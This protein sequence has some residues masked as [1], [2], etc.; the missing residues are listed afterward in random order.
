M[1][2]LLLSEGH[3]WRLG[4]GL[5]L[6]LLSHLSYEAFYFQ[7]VTIILSAAALSGRK[8][9]D[10]PWRL[11][12]SAIFLNIGCIAFN[13]LGVGGIQKSFNPDF[14]QSF[15]GGYSHI[16][17]I[18]GHAVREHRFLV[19]DAVIGAALCGS[20]YLSRLVGLARFQLSLL[21]TIG[22]IVA[23]G[24][25]YAMAGY[26]LAAEGPMARVS[27]VIATYFSIAGGVLAASSSPA[28][29]RHQWLTIAF[30]G[31]TMT[32][33][34]GLGL[35]A[36]CRVEDWADTWTFELARL[37]RLPT[38]AAP[39]DGSNRA[40][41]AIED[42]ALTAVQPAT[43]PWEIAGAVAWASSKRS[44]ETSQFL[45]TGL[46]KGEPYRWFGTIGDW[47]NRW[48]GHQLEQG[49]CANHA[50]IY[51]APASEF[52][53]WNTSTTELKKAEAPWELQCR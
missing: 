23:S 14:M 39:G 26:G 18:F 30:F 33:L 37:S 22:G 9:K 13:R 2:L 7:E 15:I 53:I 11:L 10:I 44:P 6:A 1:S 42:R 3:A 8:I 34:V 40:Y 28:N 19:L 49:Q 38:F 47:F 51:S 46:W 25:L 43:A 20:I 21:A 35:T 45:L 31:F 36:R 29:G 41:L 16:L 5:I 50:V 24:L 17:A 27:I 32:A 48:D 52:W 12:A 4:L